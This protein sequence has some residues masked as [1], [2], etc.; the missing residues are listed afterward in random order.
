[1]DPLFS[2]RRLQCKEVIPEDV[3][4]NISAATNIADRQEILFTHLSRN[5]DVKTLWEYFDVITA[6]NGFPN[7]QSFGRRRKEELQQGG[8]LVCE[9]VCVC[10][11]VGVWGGCDVTKIAAVSHV[12]A[13][14]T[15][16]NH[17]ARSTGSASFYPSLP[18]HPLDLSGATFDWNSCWPSRIRV[19]TSRVGT[20]SI[21]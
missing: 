3:V 20:I 17:Q 6:A 7:M 11:C 2:L 9:C 1:M 21:A 19:A 14:K 10:V 4:S 13:Q 12:F 8:W 5:A 16:R 15:T 18:P